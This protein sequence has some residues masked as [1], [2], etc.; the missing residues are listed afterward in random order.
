MSHVPHRIRLA[1]LL[2]LAM[3]MTA[4]SD[5]QVKR[6]ALPTGE[7]QGI[8]NNDPVKYH[9]EESHDNGHFDGVAEFLQGNEKGKRFGFHGV[10]EADGSLSLTRY[11]AGDKHVVQHAFPRLH[12]SKITYFGPIHSV[13]AGN[14]SQ[15]I[16]SLQVPPASLPGGRQKLLDVLDM[17]VKVGS[18]NT[19]HSLELLREILRENPNDRR[20]LTLQ[21]VILI[22]RRPDLAREA[23]EA[24][25]RSVANR[26]DDALLY[27][28]RA[29][30][31]ASQG[32]QKEAEEDLDRAKKLLRGGKQKRRPQA[33]LYHIY[34][35]QVY[36]RLNQADKV[37]PEYD[38]ALKLNPKL[39]D[40]YLARADF[41]GSRGLKWVTM[42]QKVGKDREVTFARPE[43]DP[44]ALREAAAEI[45]KGIKQLP[46][47][48]R[49]LHA[50][51]INAM[52]QKDHDRV[53]QTAR[54][55]STLPYCQPDHLITLAYH[56]AASPVANRRNGQA[57]I[58][59]AM[60]AGAMESPPNSPFSRQIL[61]LAHAEAGNF[62]R[63]VRLMEELE[64]ASDEM[65]LD[66]ATL[67][68]MLELFRA[69]KPYRFEP[70]K[71]K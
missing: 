53:Y 58:A 71:A 49:L 46:G 17:A 15:Y 38:Q 69:K 65:N 6:K 4:S 51:Y 43:Y 59:H 50:A 34:C 47:N 9:V 3:V 55:L 52:I 44:E 62:D 16:F 19:Q 20:A 32:K 40:V 29:V 42:K 27:S 31:R 7:Y 21:N 57:A 14:Q 68:K 24:F 26:P 1:G 22:Y 70:E 30:L 11:T 66:K 8:F 25:A 36:A 18:G 33:A 67:R 2:V 54:T 63:A 41:K 5:A 61:A 12:G 13:G 28:E 48:I 64:K 10:I 56:Q 60:L 23:E 35:A 45:E 37:T 39:P